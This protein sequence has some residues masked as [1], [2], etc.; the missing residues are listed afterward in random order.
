[1]GGNAMLFALQ[2]RRIKKFWTQ[3][4]LR[5]HL[6]D[7]I[8]NKP[9]EMSQTKGEPSICVPSEKD[10]SWFLNNGVEWV[11]SHPT[12]STMVWY[13]SPDADPQSA[14][15]G[16]IRVMSWNIELGY[17]LA[18]ICDEICRVKPDIVL[19]QEVDHIA[20]TTK[21]LSESG[22]SNCIVKD[23]MDQICQKTELHGL[24]CPAVAYCHDMADSN[25]TFRGSWGNAIL[26]NPNI[27]QPEKG[28]EKLI[29][30][31]FTP[32][33][34]RSALRLCLIPC[35]GHVDSDGED[36]E[37]I[38]PTSPK[39]H[40]SIQPLNA[41]AQYFRNV[42]F[43]TRLL[44][45]R[46]VVYST[47]L[48]VCCGVTVRVQQ[49][50][51]IVTDMTIFCASPVPSSTL[52]N[53]NC[54]LQA[55][56]STGQEYHQQIGKT[57]MNNTNLQTNPGI[58][59]NDNSYFSLNNKSSNVCSHK[60]LPLHYNINNN[61][62]ATNN[63]SFD[64]E[65]T[66]SSKNPQAHS[67]HVFIGSPELSPSRV[68]KNSE[69]VAMNSSSVLSLNRRGSVSED[70]PFSLNMKNA[71]SINTRFGLI[72]GIPEP[73]V[74][75][76]GDFNTIGH[77]ILRCSP[78]HCNDHN[79]FRNLCM[80]EAELWEKSILNPDWGLFD[81]FDKVRDTTLT[82]AAG[83][84]DAKLDW[85]LLKGLI[86]II[87]SKSPRPTDNCAPTRV[88][89]DLKSQ[90][91]SMENLMVLQKPLPFFEK[92]SSSS[93]KQSGQ[94]YHL[95]CANRNFQGAVQNTKNNKFDS[96]S[97]NTDTENSMQ[98]QQSS[99]LNST[100]ESRRLLLVSDIMEHQRRERFGAY[101]GGGDE[102]DHRWLVVDCLPSRKHASPLSVQE[103]DS[104][105]VVGFPDRTSS[106]EN[107]D[108]SNL[109]P[110]IV[111]GIPNSNSFINSHSLIKRNNNTQSV[112]NLLNG[113]QNAKFNS[114]FVSN[115]SGTNCIASPDDS[116]VSSQS[117]I[118]NTN[119]LINL[120]SPSSQKS[121][122][123]S[124]PTVIHNDNNDN[125]FIS[126]NSMLL[127]KIKH[128]SSSS[129]SFGEKEDDYQPSLRRRGSQMSAS[130]VG[131]HKPIAAANQFQFNQSELLYGLSPYDC[132]DD[133]VDESSAASYRMDTYGKKF[134]YSCFV[135]VG[136][137][138]QTRANI[139]AQRRSKEC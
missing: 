93:F 83:T 121:I 124:K 127:D 51:S 38:C 9:F 72:P 13:E 79:R 138:V 39:S 48:D 82:A 64:G 40:E 118:C 29:M 41:K 34:P 50:Q 70:S 15:E 128:F 129:L 88:R 130:S 43:K 28:S 89:R 63:K 105:P 21:V 119:N 59:I 24:F 44:P 69:W 109:I 90:S 123:S 67:T 95:H 132:G 37:E 18:R 101:I 120:P 12:P 54:I 117:N 46:L 16:S 19:L 134:S 110:A 91:I 20:Y 5:R 92:S 26:W 11:P 52:N 77:G 32:D 114:S 108:G 133:E 61:M 56:Q 131:T 106:D 45:A 31:P 7:S 25:Y 103:L 6:S 74:V 115:M 78:I 97:N 94:T 98:Q 23:C 4:H 55:A 57:M 81:P 86:P 112:G 111:N 102:S 75:I 47:H 135:K 66:S 8:S 3:K 17:N 65:I 68:T 1:M 30:L 2:K 49:F 58:N 35:Y 100:K 73:A 116:V 96:S 137:S 136:S 33:F 76:G 84:V 113:L 99:P 125:N 126:N 14:S 27:F 42:N 104:S 80:T 36:V 107:N 53:Y 87:G 122:L 62:N 22:F 139:E 10:Q 85:T 60:N 71:N